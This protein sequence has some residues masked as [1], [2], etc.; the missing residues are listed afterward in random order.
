MAFNIIYE[1]QYLL[2]K[3]EFFLKV[4]KEIL[5]FQE[6]K[7]KDKWNKKLIKVEKNIEHFLLLLQ[8]TLLNQDLINLLTKIYMKSK[9][10]I[11]LINDHDFL[12][13]LNFSTINEFVSCF[14]HIDD[15][16]RV[17]CNRENYKKDMHISLKKFYHAFFIQNNIDWFIN[18][19]PFKLLISSEL[20][21]FPIENVPLFYNFMIFRTINKSRSINTLTI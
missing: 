14:I 5:D 10:F 8:R 4:E 20:N 18:E 16:T 6:I 11:N 15:L 13:N 21:N 1:D 12:H 9:E 19:Q 7:I 17:E 2:L 3:N